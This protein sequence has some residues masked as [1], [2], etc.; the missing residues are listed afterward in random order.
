M[1]A[2]NAYII[3]AIVLLF[4]LRTLIDVIDYL[5]FYTFPKLRKR[6]ED[7]IKTLLMN[8]TLKEVRINEYKEFL[9]NIGLLPKRDMLAHFAGLRI[10]GRNSYIKREEYEKTI[11]EN[12]SKSIE[13]GD[14]DISRHAARKIKYFINLRKIYYSEVDSLNKISH[15][16]ASYIYDICAEKNII[17]DIIVCPRTSSLILNYAAAKWLD[18]KLLVL[19]KSTN[20]RIQAREWNLV[21]SDTG[22]PL[23]GKK[24]II[25]DE[26]FVMGGE[27]SS[28]YNI[29][30][31]NRAAAQDFFCIFWRK[32][33]DRDCYQLQKKEG[34][35]F[36]IMNE[37]SDEDLSR[38]TTT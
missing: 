24:V 9:D 23:I 14:F 15:A 26:S 16:F 3:S 37:Y 28:I 11:T 27:V 8:S 18:K 10:F 33:G 6:R 31:E 34:V 4:G 32:E 20:T 17:Y 13:V 19:D 12:I 2:I 38:L 22:T 21:G 25:I 7:E 35:N 1:Q 5:G 30:K 29:L 36:H